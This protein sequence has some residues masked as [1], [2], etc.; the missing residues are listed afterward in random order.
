MLAQKNQ[1]TNTTEKIKKFEK[2]FELLE[3]KLEGLG[4]LIMKDAFAIQDAGKDAVEV[5]IAI[6]ILSVIVSLLFSFF[7]V[8]NLVN[9][10]S[11]LISRLS[12]TSTELTTV[13]T[14]INSASHGLSDSASQ[15]AAALEEASASLQQLTDMIQKT[16]QNANLISNSSKTN[17][18]AAE[19]GETEIQQFIQ[20]ISEVTK[21]SKKME[22]II[23]VIDDIAFQTNLLALN[24]AVEAARAGEQGKG[25]AVVA[26]AV[27]NLA[28]RSASAAKD[29]NSIIKKNI[30]QIQ[31]SSELAS[32]SEKTLK[33]I[34]GSV[35]ESAG[36]IN[37]IQIALKEQV[38][39]LE[40]INKAVKELDRMTQQNAHSSS[41]TA[42]SAEKMIL[43][44]QSLSEVVSVM[45][46]Q[47]LDEKQS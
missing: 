12:S 21:N 44:S 39:G 30:G 4:E 15:S 11:Q 41:D 33:G 25:F 32:R 28:Q 45:K 43:Q 19:A 31:S 5:G 29:I 9:K 13:S 18:S 27:R 47:I 37:D 1:L 16:S 36:L 22:E 17:A 2:E 46:E 10:M 26:E 34:V 40:Q 6:T 38:E 24:A 7:I 42:A 8:R 3:E 14:N 20:V 35:R 23:N